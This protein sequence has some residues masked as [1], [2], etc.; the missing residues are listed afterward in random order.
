MTGLRVTQLLKS[1]PQRKGLK[2][3]I[4]AFPAN[5][6]GDATAI[7]VREELTA[8]TKDN[9][10]I[11]T[12]SAEVFRPEVNLSTRILTS[13]L[14]FSPLSFIYPPVE[15]LPVGSERVRKIVRRSPRL[16]VEDTSDREAT[17]GCYCH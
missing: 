15:A 10:F 3:V 7:R 17:C 6:E 13:S 1:I 8:L 11:I 9:D 12:S 16:Y 2:E 5:P 14:L 4:L